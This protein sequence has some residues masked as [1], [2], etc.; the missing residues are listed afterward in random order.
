MGKRRESR[1]LAVQ[2]LFSHD[3]RDFVDELD[4]SFPAF[5]EMVEKCDETTK[6]HVEEL[7]RGVLAHRTEIDLMLRSYAEKWTL[8]RMSVVDRNI[9]RLGLFE[10]H[11]R[12]DIP[13]VAAM[14]EAIELAKLLGGEE[15]KRF[16]NGI[17]N[18]A[19]KD[20]KKTLR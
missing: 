13:P 4:K 12:N 15:S 11:H 19:T 14:N 17:L 3:V 20:L 5:W 7:V 6:G 9:L 8:E 16:V 2:F 10:M 18:R 1:T